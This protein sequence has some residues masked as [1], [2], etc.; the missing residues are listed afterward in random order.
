MSLLF[1]TVVGLICAS[2]CHTALPPR[3]VYSATVVNESGKPLS[4]FVSWSKIEH[5][6]LRSQ[7]FDLGH[8]QS[9]SAR[10]QVFSMGTWEARAAI[11]KIQCGVMVLQAPFDN[12]HGPSENWRFVITASGIKS[13]GSA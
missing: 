3:D 12:V 1:L 9:F 13:V 5:Q 6:P 10:E 11:E 8:A 4:C 2:V 7:K